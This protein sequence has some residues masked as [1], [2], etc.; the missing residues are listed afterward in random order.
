VSVALR[1]GVYRALLETQDRFGK[2]VT[3]RKTVHVIDPGARSF[4]A[5]LPN[6]LTAPKWSVEPGQTF[7]ALWGTGYEEGRAFVEVQCNG[8]TLQSFWTDPDRTQ[9]FIE[10]EITGEM[11]GGL[12]LRVTSVRENRAYFT[13]RV[14]DVPWSN[15][16]LAITWETFRSK[17]VP[18]QEETWKATLTGP[19]AKRAT[20]EMVAGLYDAALDQFLPHRWASGFPVFR[21]EYLRRSSVLHNLPLQFRGLHGHWLTEPA[22]S[23]NWTYRS[24]PHDFAPAGQPWSYV[25]RGIGDEVIQLTPF[26]V[27]TDMDRGYAAASTLSGGRTD[28][29]LGYASFGGASGQAHPSSEG[30][31]ALPDLAKIAARKNLNETAFFFPH[32]RADRRGEVTLSFTTPE[33]LTEWRFFGFAHDKQLRAGFLQDTAVTA[34]DLM[35]QPNPPRFVR[36]GDAIEFAVK[37]S[38]QSERAQSGKVRLTFADAAT[39]EPVDAALGNRELDQTFSIPA[40]ESRTYTW[41]IA[42]PDGLGFLT[43]KVV[44][45]TAELSDGEEGYLPVLSRRVLVTESLPLPVRGRGTRQVEFEK[46]IGSEASG[47]LR[48]RSLTVQ[49]VSQPAWYAVLALPYLMEFPHA[50]SEQ[51]FSRLYANVLARHIADSDPKIRRI[52]EQW[53]NTSVLDSPLEKNGDLKSV[54]LE[55]TPWLRQAKDESEA[56][57]NVGLLFDANRLEGETARTLHA[58]AEQ[59][60]GDGFWPWFPDGPPN[61]FTSLYIATGFGRL[62]QLGVSIDAAPA[63]KAWPALD[64]WMD[65]RTRRIVDRDS[66]VPGPL[67]AL[68]LYGRSFFMGDRPLFAPHRETVDYLLTQ[69][70][71]F[72][73]H[74]GGRQSQAHLALALQR[75]GD[76]TTAR[77]IVASLKERSVTDAELGMFWRD[78]ELNWWWF[79]APIETQALMIEAFAEVTADARAV[80]DCQVWLLK[81]KQVQGWKTTKATADAIYALLLRGSNLLASDARVEVALGGEPARPKRTEAGTGFYERTFAAAEIKPAMGRITLTKPDDGVSWGSVHWQYLEEVGKIT[82]HEATPL[83]IEKTLFVKETTARGQVLKPVSGPVAVGDEL[84]VRLEVRT[85]RDMEYLHLKDQRGSGTEPVNVISRYRYQDGLAYY[86]STRDTATHFFIDYLP[87]GTYVLEYSSRVQLKGSYHTGLAEIQC[88]YAPEFNSHSASLALEVR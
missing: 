47:T 30:N 26:E 31:E 80:E 5:K 69:A 17:L 82:A 29:E 41:R 55:E 48:H 18:G 27:S 35:V 34:K 36:E 87:K 13:A 72:W 76:P 58:L 53:R 9:A 52:F 75:F 37:V 63:L 44:G 4:A 45:S 57:R 60:L 2:K 83:T 38:N 24:Y 3:A 79:R 11:R 28:L 20:A 78:L 65:A 77:A 16:Q 39:L 42:V 71:K 81:Q 7:T 85:D 40:R 6:L 54:L 10:Q 67:D 74:V 8:K 59:Q 68:Y 12:T 61:E 73:L 64:A 21:R 23:V 84:V 33:A 66:Y 19:G 1:T 86:E 43:Y 51:L 56:R 62:R 50:C 14:I 22:R 15:K 70:R 32:V 49:M 88:M 25:L 46:L